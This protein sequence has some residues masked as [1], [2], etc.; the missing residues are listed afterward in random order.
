MA[1]SKK[2]FDYNWIAELDNNEKG[3]IG[4]KI[5]EIYLK[6]H[7]KSH[8]DINRIDVHYDVK[9]HANTVNKAGQHEHNFWI[10]DLFFQSYRPDYK[11]LVEVKTGKY[12]ELERSQRM[13]MKW[14]ARSSNKSVLRSN[15]RLGN[16][17]FKIKT[18][19]IKPDS[20]QLVALT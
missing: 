15:V 5:A 7:L 12:A 4:E 11:I 6:P 18:S 17:G 19:Q 14:L 20:N 16:D 3:E 13:V 2:E 9:F 8:F 1:A 10:A